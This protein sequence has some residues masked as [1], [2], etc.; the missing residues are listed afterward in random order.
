MFKHRC[1]RVMRFHHKRDHE[2]LHRHVLHDLLGEDHCE[3]DVA[4]VG[5]GGSTAS[6]GRT[7]TGRMLGASCFQKDNLGAPLLLGM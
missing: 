5:F 6:G 3:W 2:C 7:S 4:L 1:Y